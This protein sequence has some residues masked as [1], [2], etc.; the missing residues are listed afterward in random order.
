MVTECS[1]TQSRPTPP[2]PMV[3]RGFPGPPQGRGEL[4]RPGPFQRGLP[5]Q[6]RPREEA[7]EAGARGLTTS[8]KKPVIAG[9]SVQELSGR[10]RRTVGLEA[11]VGHT[12]GGKAVPSL[13][14]GRAPP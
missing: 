11:E 5:N 9:Q 6:P 8:L 4:S 1:W 3:T 14:E 10:R 12:C 7:A 13:W 2:T